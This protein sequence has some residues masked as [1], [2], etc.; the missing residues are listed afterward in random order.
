MKTKVLRLF[1]H[2][3]FFN[4]TWAQAL[5]KFPNSLR[6]VSVGE[7]PSCGTIWFV[8]GPSGELKWFKDSADSSN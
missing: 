6:E 8:E 2:S 5:E 4:L 1:Q 7:K 3:N